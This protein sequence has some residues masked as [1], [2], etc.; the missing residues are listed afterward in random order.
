MPLPLCWWK[1]NAKQ[2]TTTPTSYG[3]DIAEAVGSRDG[4]IRH[5]SD[6]KH[7]DAV[8]ILG[9]RL[10]MAQCCAFSAYGHQPLNDYALR[11]RRLLIAAAPRVLALRHKRAPKRTN[12]TATG[13]NSLAT[14]AAAYAARSACWLR[15]RRW[16]A[17]NV[18]TDGGPTTTLLP[19]QLLRIQRAV[20]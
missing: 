3:S 8:P 6:V 19:S 17:Q 14:T 12:D 2:S 13:V 15:K 16:R 7:T 10:T 4:N 5:I 9:R 20:K 1:P 11:C 18:H